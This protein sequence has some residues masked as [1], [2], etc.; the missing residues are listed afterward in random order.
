MTLHMMRAFCILVLCQIPAAQITL[1]LQPELPAAF[2]QGDLSWSA[3]SA[4]APSLCTRLTAQHAC[5]T[6]G[7]GLPQVVHRALPQ[8]P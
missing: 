5:M 2:W 6:V 7:L 8:L 3:E 1:H 4:Q